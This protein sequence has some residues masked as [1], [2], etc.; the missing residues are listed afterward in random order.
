MRPPLLA[1]WLLLC[2]G[3]LAPPGPAERLNN[4]A[5]ELNTAT[6]F[7]RMDVAVGRV[8][9]HERERFMAR[10]ARWGRIKRIVDVELEGVRLLTP[11][12]AEVRLAVSW[13]RLDES[14]L[15]T[16]LVAQKWMEG[17]Q[18]WELVEEIRAGGDPGLFD[19]APEPKRKK[20]VEVDAPAE[21]AQR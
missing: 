5:Y 1:A 9:T 7:G 4:T 21:T 2:A 19:A 3:C 20:L 8:A 11:S 12:T 18:D 6:R 17:K 10:H 16:S 14:T 13:Q 15:R